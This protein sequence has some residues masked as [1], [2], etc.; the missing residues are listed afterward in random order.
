MKHEWTDA[1]GQRWGITDYD[2]MCYEYDGKWISP[3]FMSSDAHI[4]EILRLA[5]ETARLRAVI[6]KNA[7]PLEALNTDNGLGAKWMH[8]ELRQEVADACVRSRAALS[9]AEED[10]R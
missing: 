3:G 2:I 4:A 10:A 6:A 8:H 7:V 1:E 9:T 5:D